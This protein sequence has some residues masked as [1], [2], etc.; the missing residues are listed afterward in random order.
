MSHHLVQVTDLTHAYPDGTEA[1]RRVTLTITHG[2]SVAI[3]GAN[4]A[5]K[6]T[7]LLHLIGVLAPTAGEVRVGDLPM[8]RKTLPQV[9]RAVGFVFQDPDDQL[10]MPTVY[11]DVAFGPL[12][13]GLP[14]LEVD[15]RVAE[16]LSAVRAEHLRDRPPYR[17]SGGE[18]RAAAIA[19]VLAMHPDILVMDEPTAGLDPHAR[20]QLIG[21]LRTFQHT[22]V[23]ATHDLDMAVDVCARTIVLGQ[24]QV[25][26]DGPTLEIFADSDLLRRSDLEKPLRMQGC[27]V[28]GHRP[29][30]PDEAARQPPACGK[31]N[32]SLTDLED[33][34]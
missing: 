2:E 33:I 25:V 18:K 16:A 3:V 7:L 11:E 27:P 10:F 23:I 4:G 32:G 24:G 6:T 34:R 22:K 12:N 30:P 29:E 19:T 5:G 17:L 20:R 9:R 8:T 14:P 28:C 26:A 15:A 13:L 21:L 31:T 1:L